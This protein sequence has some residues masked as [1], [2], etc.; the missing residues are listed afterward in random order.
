[1][2]EALTLQNNNNKKCLGQD[3]KHFCLSGK[4]KEKFS[5]NFDAN[6]NLKNA[7]QVASKIE[8]EGEK[9]RLGLDG[10]IAGEND[11]QYNGRQSGRMAE[12][13]GQHRV[14]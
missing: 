6:W 2:H 5:G 1:M 9:A 4:R 3:L 8:T 14:V 12:S 11:T 10:Y 13:L 7:R